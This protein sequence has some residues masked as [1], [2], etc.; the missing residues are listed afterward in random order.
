MIKKKKCSKCKEPKTL[1]EFHNDR[2]KADG[3][4]TQCAECINKRAN[5]AKKEKRDVERKTREAIKPK[6]SKDKI[7][8]NRDGSMISKSKCLPGCNDACIPCENKQFDNIKA[9]GDTLTPEGH[10]EQTL[11]G[12]YRSSALIAVEG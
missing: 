12:T 5:L 7:L 10:R 11:S 1:D 6:I 8:C 3:K 4:T 2:S 9:S